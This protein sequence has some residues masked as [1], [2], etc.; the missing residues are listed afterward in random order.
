MTQPMPCDQGGNQV[1]CVNTT[2]PCVDA[3]DPLCQNSTQKDKLQAEVNVPCMTN[4]TL[5]VNLVD[6]DQTQ[7]N[8]KYTY[9][10]TTMAVAGPEYKDCEDLKNS[11][12]YSSVLNENYE[13]YLETDDGFKRNYSIYTHKRP[14]ESNGQ[15]NMPVTVLVKCSDSA[16]KLCPPGALITCTTFNEVMCMAAV[17][18]V[19]DCPE[20]NSTCFNSTIPCPAESKEDFC[21]KKTEG[22]DSVTVEVPCF[23]N[24]TL[25]T[26]FPKFN[27]AEFNGTLPDVTVTSSYTYNFNY[28][29]MTLA[30]PGS[31]F[32]LCITKEEKEKREKQKK[33]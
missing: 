4:V 29:V 13:W 5:D 18:D 10:V 7:P 28:C 11:N 1:M 17:E 25:N 33:T 19:H 9:C 32:D 14:M 23:A 24:I 6:K 22:S 15:I 20:Q 3:N 2:V 12:D 16:K 31:D 26:P 8:T 21:M 27:L 30:L